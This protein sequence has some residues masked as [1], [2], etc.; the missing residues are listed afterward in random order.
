MPIH[1]WSSVRSLVYILVVR[2][3]L[4]FDIHNALGAASGSVLHF[5]IL[6]RQKIGLFMESVI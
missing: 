1:S 2:W 3:I 4:I 5:M 6:L